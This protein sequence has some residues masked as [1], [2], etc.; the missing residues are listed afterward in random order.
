MLEFIQELSESRLFKNPRQLEG[1]SKRQMA[2]ALFVATLALNILRY[3]NPNVA[4]RYAK[5]TMI[6]GLDGWRSSGSDYSNLAYTLLNQERYKERMINDAVVSVPRLQLTRWLRDI[7]KEKYDPKGDYRFFMSLQR[8]LNIRQPGLMNA[9]RLIVD[10]PRLHDH[11][12]QLATTKIYQE[13]HRLLPQSDIFLNFKKYATKRN[14][15][16]NISDNF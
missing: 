2:D 9:R 6:Y 4:T 13:L 10:W 15:M 8:N 12:K 16:V 7:G 3:E 1:E 14:A 11:E 5:K